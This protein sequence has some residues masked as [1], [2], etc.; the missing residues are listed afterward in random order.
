MMEK[1]WKIVVKVKGNDLIRD[2]I[3]NGILSFLKDE[4]KDYRWNFDISLNE[5]EENEQ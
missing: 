4:C 5:D 1:K 2:F 3:T